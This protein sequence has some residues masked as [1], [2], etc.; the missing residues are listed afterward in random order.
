VP[1]EKYAIPACGFRYLEH[2]ET[3]LLDAAALLSF[4][5]KKT[6]WANCVDIVKIPFVLTEL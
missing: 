2:S 4:N 1:A 3:N 6:M 5:L